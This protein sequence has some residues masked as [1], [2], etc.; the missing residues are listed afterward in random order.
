[1]DEIRDNRSL[2]QTRVCKNGIRVYQ[3]KIPGID[4]PD[5]IAVRNGLLPETDRIKNVATDLNDLS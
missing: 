2:Y 1:M 5:V 4:L 3:K